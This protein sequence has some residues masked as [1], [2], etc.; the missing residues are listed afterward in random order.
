MKTF[1]RIGL[2]ISFIAIQLALVFGGQIAMKEIDNPLLL[3]ILSIIWIGLNG[4]N[5]YSHG[6]LLGKNE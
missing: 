4:L 3:F 2:I 1:I 6:V 5:G